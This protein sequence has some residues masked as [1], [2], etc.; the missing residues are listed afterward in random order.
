MSFVK[1]LALVVV[2]LVSLEVGVEVVD[3]R[4]LDVLVR[5]VALVCLAA[6]GH[7]VVRISSLRSP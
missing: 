6:V 7:Q 4:R 2:M 5:I 3:D 1:G